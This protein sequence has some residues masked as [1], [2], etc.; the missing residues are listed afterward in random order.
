MGPFFLLKGW[1]SESLFVSLGMKEIKK[2]MTKN[3]LELV[4]MNALDH[5]ETA[6][7]DA[8]K[9]AI[10]YDGNG[11]ENL[12]FEV[13]FLQ[14]RINAALYYLEKSGLMSNTRLFS[15]QD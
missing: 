3:Q 6:V 5:L 13:G 7:D 12:A 14:A 4:I 9:A 2:V 1:K 10:R 15:D 11:E 8:K